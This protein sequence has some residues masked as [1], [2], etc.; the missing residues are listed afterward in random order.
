MIVISSLW[1]LT[2]FLLALF[3]CNPIAK[4]WN[5]TMQGTCIGWGSKDPADFFRM[6]LGHAVSNCV[7]DIMVLLVPVPFVTT[8]RIAGKSRAGLV[9]LFS[10]GCV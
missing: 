1:G 2:F 3:P 6:F 7:L 8:L 5:P 10:L 9:G 4:N